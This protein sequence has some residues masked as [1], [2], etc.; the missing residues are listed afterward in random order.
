MGRLNVIIHV[1]HLA[2]DLTQVSYCHD[3][4]LIACVTHLHSTEYISFERSEKALQLSPESFRIFTLGVPCLG[5]QLPYYEQPMPYGQGTYGSRPSASINH[6]PCEHAILD[7][8]AP[9][10]SPQMTAA[11]RGCYVEQ[12]NHQLSPVNCR[13]TRDHI[14]V[15]I[16]TNSVLGG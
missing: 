8:P 11:P 3:F 7:I 6:W 5:T 15:I 13:L 1:K 2:L 16:L 14:T 4:L 10:S 12:K 9:L